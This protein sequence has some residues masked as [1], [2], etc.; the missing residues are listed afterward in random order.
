MIYEIGSTG[1]IKRFITHKNVP[2]ISCADSPV[3][4]QIVIFDHQL[5]FVVDCSHDLVREGID[6][7]FGVVVGEVEDSGG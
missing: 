3:R 6:N 1:K 7:E 4:R 2:D 5:A